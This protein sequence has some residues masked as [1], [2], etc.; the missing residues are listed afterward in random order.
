MS[1]KRYYEGVADWAENMRRLLLYGHPFAYDWMYRDIPE[2]FRD[3]DAPRIVDDGKLFTDDEIKEAERMANDISEH[4]GVDVVVH[5]VYNT[6]GE[7]VES[8]A[9]RFYYANGY[10]L[11]EDYSGILVNVI[12]RPE[13]DSEVYVSCYGSIEGYNG[14]EA[15]SRLADRFKSAIDLGPGGQAMDLYFSMLNH[16]FLTG[17]TP[18]S[19]G[20]WAATILFAFTVGLIVGAV[21][22]VKARKGMETPEIKENTLPYLVP[23]SL[24]IRNVR[25]TYLNSTKTMKKRYTE[26]GSSSGRS[27]SG[28]SSYSSSYSGSSGRSHSGSG[29]SF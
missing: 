16:M 21:S 5:T 23:G 1:G 18:R 13:Y 22:L 15:V 14:T 11:G 7:A 28:R 19:A 26:S 9:D 29:R 12:K 20:S 24:S 17:R 4:F 27:S 2:D 3:P 25:D 6:C 10:G 8:Y